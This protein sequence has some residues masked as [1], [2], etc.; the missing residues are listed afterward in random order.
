LYAIDTSRGTATLDLLIAYLRT[1]LPRLRTEGS[2]IGAEAELVDA[3]LAVV[4]ARRNGV[5]TRRIEVE[6]A[7]SN[8][9]FPATV[10]LPLAQ[11]AV[12]DAAESAGEVWL[13]IRP[14]NE[15]RVDRLQVRLHVAPGHPCSDDDAEPRRIRERL[16]AMYGDAAELT[17]SWNPAQGGPDHGPAT[18]ATVITLRWPDESAD[19]DRR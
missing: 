6:P 8:A 14:A 15:G 19:R 10:L 2:T 1:A 16:H 3:W 4:A 9:P 12:G 5:P 13:Q 7:C 17:C 18:P 11:W